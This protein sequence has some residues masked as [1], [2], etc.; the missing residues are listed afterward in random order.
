MVASGS[1]VRR[2]YFYRRENEAKQKTYKKQLR[3]GSIDN[4]MAS[5]RHH[6]GQCTF[7]LDKRALIQDNFLERS[8]FKKKSV[9]QAMMVLVHP[10]HFKKIK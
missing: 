2:L 4:T 8:N 7:F 9:K 1:N 10:R 3:R 6:Q 5:D